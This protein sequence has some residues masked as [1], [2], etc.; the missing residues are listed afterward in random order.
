[1]AE[2]HETFN[3]HAVLRLL[4]E[5]DRR[6][7]DRKA[8]GSDEWQY[9]LNSPVS[10]DLVEE[11]ERRHGFTLP[12][13]YRTFLTEIGNGGAGPYYGVFPFGW[14][15]DGD[16]YRVWKDGGLVGDLSKP[17]PHVDSWNLPDSFWERQPNPPPD[18]P[19]EEKDRMIEAWD[20]ELEARYWGPA[21][22]NGA[23]PICHLGCALRQWLVLNGGQKGYVWQDDRADSAGIRPLR[24]REGNQVTFSDW[25]LA[26]LF[27]SLNH[28]ANLFGVDGVI[29]WPQL[30][31]E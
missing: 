26:W 27:E 5:L 2:M 8:F 1:M 25:Y 22:M 23:I 30:C 7:P 10:L 11:F 6:D 12:D 31:A 9:K 29:P 14:H 21:I 3:K 24:D 20:R 13:D 18:T 4:N 15:D 16:G 17:F 19:T 28:P